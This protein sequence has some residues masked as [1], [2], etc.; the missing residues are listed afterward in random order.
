[1]FTLIE[2]AK[3]NSKN[4]EDYL[5]CIFEKAPYARTAEDWKKLLPWNIEIAPFKMRGEWVE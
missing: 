4:P 1:M 3:A 5:R 2:T